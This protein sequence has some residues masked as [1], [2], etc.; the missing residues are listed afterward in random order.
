MTSADPLAMARAVVVFAIFARIGVRARESAA[1]RSA[2]R[3]IW[4]TTSRLWI[5]QLAETRG[6][7]ETRRRARRA[8][9]DA[10]RDSGDIEKKLN[11]FSS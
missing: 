3:E 8:R 2:A 5:G 6:E 1:S 9:V 10:E 7:A 11:S 4:I